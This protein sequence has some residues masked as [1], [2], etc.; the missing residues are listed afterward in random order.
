MRLWDRPNM[1][2]EGPTPKGLQDSTKISTL[3][4]IKNKWFALK[5]RE[6]TRIL[7]LILSKTRAHNRN[8]SRWCMGRPRA[9]YTNWNF[10]SDRMPQLRKP[11]QI[12]R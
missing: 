7:V 12:G 6:N 4:I 2:P 10:V 8:A 3:E 11:D 9:T 1:Q 5:G